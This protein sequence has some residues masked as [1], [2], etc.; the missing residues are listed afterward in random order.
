MFYVTNL[1]R[2]DAMD[3]SLPASSLQGDS[4]GKNTGVGCQALLEGIFSTQGLNPG[5]PHSR[6]ILYQLGYQ[7]GP[8]NLI[9][10]L[11]VIHI[12]RNLFKNISKTD[13]DAS[14]FITHESLFLS[15]LKLCSLSDLWGP[16]WP[17]KP[18]LSDFL[19][20][21]SPP[22]FSLLATSLW[23]YL[24]HAGDVPTAAVSTGTSFG[25]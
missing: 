5:K 22:C 3:C 10:T 13:C 19:F 4:P 24:R 12:K 2:C 6:Q 16:N 25:T 15:H 20:Y 23:S 1:T 17:T 18:H 21:Y 14:V 11:K 9:K 8:T 7:G